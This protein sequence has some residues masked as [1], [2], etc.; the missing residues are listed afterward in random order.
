MIRA[1]L[2]IAKVGKGSLV[3]DPFLGSGTTAVEA[4][5]LGADFV[6][7][8]VSPLCV[9]LSKVKTTAWRSA[10]KIKEAVQRLLGNPNLQ[11]SDISLDNF[12]GGVREFIEIA[13][14]VTA[15]DVEVRDRDESRYLAK[16]LEKMLESV[17]AM[18][19][20]VDEFGLEPGEPRLVRGDV[21]NLGKAKILPGSV[22]AIVTS[23]PYSIALDYVKNDKHALQALGEDLKAIR[24]DFIGLKGR[25]A[26]ERIS[27]Y[28]EDMRVAFDQMALILKPGAHL[29]MVVGDATVGGEEKTS[30]DEMVTWAETSGLLLERKMPKIVFGL[31]NIMSDEKILFFRRKG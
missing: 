14:M 31:Y 29:M 4:I 24:K 1:L 23:P 19:K 20:A 30:T 6:G 7:V 8:D 17:I 5:L 12:S 28:N 15:S 2:N 27:I 13:L 3:V 9:K 11:K 10:D 16:N 21:R 25:G 18:K 22:D 26:K